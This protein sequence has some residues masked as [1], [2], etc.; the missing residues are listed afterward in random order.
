MDRAQ[1]PANMAKAPTPDTSASSGP[2]GHSLATAANVPARHYGAKKDNKPRPVNLLSQFVE[3]ITPNLLNQRP[4]HSCKSRMAEL[5]GEADLLAMAVD[6]LWEQQ[7]PY[8]SGAGCD[9]GRPAVPFGI[10]KIGLRGRGHHQ[11][12]R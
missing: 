8:G 12:R 1:D 10:A 4:K 3:T 11:D 2:R 7:N 9:P 6:M 5:R